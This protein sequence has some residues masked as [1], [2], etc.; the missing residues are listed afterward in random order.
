MQYPPPHPHSVTQITAFKLNLTK[1]KID[2]Q[3]GIFCMAQD[4]QT[5]AVYQPR[6]VRWGGRWEGIPKGRGYIYIYIYTH[7]HTHTHTYG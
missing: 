1:Y 5:G 4:S 2:S 6:G 3:I 7:T